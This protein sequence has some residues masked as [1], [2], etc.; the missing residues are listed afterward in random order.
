MSRMQ[1][2][3]SRWHTT[4]ASWEELEFAASMWATFQADDHFP[5]VAQS[6][7][8]N[9]RFFPSPEKTI[10]P[11]TETPTND[12]LKASA[13]VM[14]ESPTSSQPETPKELTLYGDI[15]QSGSS[16]QSSQDTHQRNLTPSYQTT[17]EHDVIFGI[18]LVRAQV[19]QNLPTSPPDASNTLATATPP[20]LHPFRPTKMALAQQGLL[21]SSAHG[22]DNSKTRY[23]GDSISYV[24]QL[25]D[26][27]NDKNCALFITNIPQ[28][29]S[30]SDIFD[31]IDVGAVF[32]LHIS[33]AGG[34]HITK[35]AKLVFM[36]PEAAH[37]M[38]EK[39]IWMRGK[40][41]RLT[42]NRHGYPRNDRH[43]SRVVIVEGPER[44]MELA[45]WERYFR[46]Y[47]DLV[48]DRVLDVECATSSHKAYAFHFSRVDGQAETCFRAIKS[49]PSFQGYI[50][51]RYGQDP[52]GA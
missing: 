47:S 26:L 38:M 37:L 24:G 41:L 17:Q 19:L 48:Y 28:I 31:K 2:T 11:V 46:N 10:T 29:V 30:H 45:T 34:T 44:V 9:S 39:T 1:R 3:P 18:A 32:A 23:H 52:C 20:V 49:E 14:A 13:L 5:I 42:Y 7:L 33:P 21:E 35:A 4:R 43:Y 51:V 15:I 27:P 6:P 12:T 50:T 25:S 40:R 16:S 8:V 22:S 36:G